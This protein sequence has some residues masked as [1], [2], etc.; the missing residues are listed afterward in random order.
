M[1]NNMV[2]GFSEY[3]AAEFLDSD[4]MITT[5]LTEVSKEND[6]RMLSL[7]LGDVARAK[8]MTLLARET[9]I[10]RDGLYK[11]F[12]E[13]GNPTLETLSKVANALGMKV[14]LVAK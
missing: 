7:A 11:S 10:S 3:D 12:G 1:V 13:N 2:K 9:G 6:P 14:V 5:Y 4:E 8:G